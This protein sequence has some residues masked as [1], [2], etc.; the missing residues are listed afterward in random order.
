MGAPAHLAAKAPGASK[1]QEFPG[2]DRLEVSKLHGL[3][4][5]PLRN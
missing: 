2:K 5:L 1:R 4:S 3:R